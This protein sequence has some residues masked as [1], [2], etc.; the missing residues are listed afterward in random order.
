MLSMQFEKNKG[1]H[2]KHDFPGKILIE[3]NGTKHFVP[4]FSI[5]IKKKMIATYLREVLNENP[6]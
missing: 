4:C 2:F 3:E 6:S 5:E 1:K